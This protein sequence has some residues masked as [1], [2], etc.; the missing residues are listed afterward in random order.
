MNQII[1]VEDVREAA[2]EALKNDSSLTKYKLAKTLNL[3]TASHINNF[4]TGNTKKTRLAVKKLFFT[5]LNILIKDFKDTPEYKR[6]TEKPT[7]EDIK[8]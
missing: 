5:R 7:S 3:S 6:L 1:E 4:L 8:V 2:M